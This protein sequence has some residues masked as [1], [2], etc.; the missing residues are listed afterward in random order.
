M[1]NSIRTAIHK[2]TAYNR[3]VRELKSLPTDLAIEDLGIVTYDADR[4]AYKA[5]YGR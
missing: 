1:I 3:T 2:R 4:I 5:V